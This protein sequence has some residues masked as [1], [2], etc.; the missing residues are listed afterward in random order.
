ME[1]VRGGRGS[2]LAVEFGSAS[3]KSVPFWAAV[4]V[5]VAVSS[6]EGEEFT[7]SV[8]GRMG[9]GCESGGVRESV[10]SEERGGGGGGEGGGEA[11]GRTLGEITSL[12]QVEA[13]STSWDSSKGASPA[14]D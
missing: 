8:T 1:S 5:V 11:L 14:E 2:R 13:G 7:M 12:M 3:T 6:S 10:W 9:S 4:V